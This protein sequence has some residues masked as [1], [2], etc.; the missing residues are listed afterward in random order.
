MQRF[1]HFDKPNKYQY[2]ISVVILTSVFFFIM[3]LIL[4]SCI[5]L[6]DMIDVVFA[7]VIIMDLTRKETRPFQSFV[8][9]FP[10]QLMEW[11][12]IEYDFDCQLEF[13]GQMAT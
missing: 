3:T 11:K 13:F 10:L 4:I 8:A 5:W 9:T 1:S 2:F 7:I 12:W 6:L